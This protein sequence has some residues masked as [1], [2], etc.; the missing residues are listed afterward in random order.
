MND[1]DL[2]QRAARI[3]ALVKELDSSAAPDM[4]ERVSELLQGLLQLYGEG[5]G[6]ILAFAEQRDPLMPELF[7][8]DELIAHL[9]YLHDLH[10]I[11]IE[12]RVTAALDDIQPY[13][14]AQ[15]AKAELSGLHAGMVAV[16]LTTPGGCAAASI[17]QRVEEAVRTA[18]PD[19]ATVE[20]AMEVRNVA[21]PEAMFI[22]LSE[23]SRPVPARG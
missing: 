21:V 11:P 9:L 22:P 7:A 12:T 13:L 4:R 3:E 1:T 18:A 2:K 5:L 20:V 17:K 19:L 14:Q 10:P 16:C 8:Q 6:R 15:G 23:V